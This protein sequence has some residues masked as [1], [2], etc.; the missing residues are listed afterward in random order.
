MSVGRFWSSKFLN[1]FLGKFIY[2][3]W[4]VVR[5]VEDVL[6]LVLIAEEAKVLEKLSSEKW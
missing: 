4:A 1:N 5:A 3:F 2:L 6:Y